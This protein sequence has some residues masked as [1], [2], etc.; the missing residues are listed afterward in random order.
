MSYS[1]LESP[2]SRRELDR[3]F[4]RQQG[5]ESAIPHAEESLCGDLDELGNWLAWQAGTPR[6]P[7]KYFG[8]ISA[9]ELVLVLLKP[10]ATLEQVAAASQELRSRYLAARKQAVQRIA[11]EMSE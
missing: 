9:Q 7:S 2:A 6:Q 1:T 11:E 8:P 3:I 10:S 5:V 4:A